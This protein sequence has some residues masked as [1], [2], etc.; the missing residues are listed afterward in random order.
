MRKINSLFM[1]SFS[2]EL[3]NSLEA[4]Y[5][6]FTEYSIS[7]VFI[8]GAARNQYAPSRITEDID[9]L[10]NFYDLDKI[11]NLPIGYIRDLTGNSRSLKLHN[12][13]TMIDVI[14]TGEVAGDQRGIIYYIENINYI[15]KL[16]FLSL[17][18]LIRFKLS[19]GLYGNR[20]KNFGDVQDLILANGLNRDFA[21]NFRQDLKDKYNEILNLIVK[22]L[23]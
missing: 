11:K 3:N 14:Y 7:F 22:E 20:L 4:I 15:D 19:A 9:I 17:E 21:K 2:K 10:V 1:D 13:E 8:G 16:P 5:N 6:L 18:N 23:K 12:P